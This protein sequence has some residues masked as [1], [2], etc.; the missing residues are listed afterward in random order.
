MGKQYE[1]ICFIETEKKAKTSV[2]SCRT[3]SNDT[4]LGQ[5]KWYP[6]W[7]QYCYFSTTHAVYSVGCLRD[8][9]KFIV[10]TNEDHNNLRK[11]QK[12]I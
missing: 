11:K 10:S 12:R 5:V 7:R 2:F 3:N 9:E 6:A 4:E 1:Y 8:I